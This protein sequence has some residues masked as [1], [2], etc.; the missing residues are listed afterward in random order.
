MQSEDRIEAFGAWRSDAV[1]ADFAVFRDVVVPA[2]R[3]DTF[4]GGATAS[5]KPGRRAA[6]EL[7]LEAGQLYD[8]DVASAR[9]EVRWRAGRHWTVSQYHEISRVRLDGGRFTAHVTRTR[10][11]WRGSTRLGAGATVQYDN[12]SDR[13]GLSLRAAYLFREGTELILAIDHS[14]DRVGLGR[15]LGER[16]RTT[17]L[18]KL[19]YLLLR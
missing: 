6:G 8:G 18:L 15:P 5:T 14:G 13:L 7:T 9:S 2:A 19:T 3:Y 12:A 4:R 1:L 11:Q 17:A 10:L 16:E